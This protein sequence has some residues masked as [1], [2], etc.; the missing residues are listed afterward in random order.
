MSQDQPGSPSDPVAEQKCCHVK[1]V[2]R[3]H[4]DRPDPVFEKSI[5]IR[6]HEAIQ[7]GSTVRGGIVPGKLSEGLLL[8]G[9]LVRILVRVSAE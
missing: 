2:E 5:L 4:I 8:P 6:I 9:L 7:Q 3:G 1:H